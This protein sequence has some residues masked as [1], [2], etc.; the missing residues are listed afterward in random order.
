MCGGWCVLHLDVLSDYQVRL[1]SALR[2]ACVSNS[3]VSL[4]D[5]CRSMYPCGV[6]IRDD[7]KLI[8]YMFDLDYTRPLENYTAKFQ[9]RDTF[10]YACS[11]LSAVIDQAPIDVLKC[12]T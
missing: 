3:T 1:G 9:R 7:H 5:G 8:G 6:Y 2:L 12:C 11:L 4:K 10:C